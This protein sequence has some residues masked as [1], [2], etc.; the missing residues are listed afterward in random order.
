MGKAFNLAGLVQK[1]SGGR[2]S[3]LGFDVQRGFYTNERQFFMISP[4]F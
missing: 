3:F 2:C 1:A 4:L